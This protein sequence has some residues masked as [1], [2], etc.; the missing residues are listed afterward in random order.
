MNS[1]EY[2][3]LS[4]EEKRVKVAE[5]CGWKHR[6][7]GFPTHED[8][9]WTHPVME[10]ANRWYDVPAYLHD[11]NAMHEAEM[12]LDGNERGRKCSLA[13]LYSGILGII[14]CDPIPIHATAAQRAKAFVLTMTGGRCDR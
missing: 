8:W 10:C 6:D 13:T 4:D 5:L 9:I 14:C 2:D 1:S 7:N 3:K 11:L 12:L